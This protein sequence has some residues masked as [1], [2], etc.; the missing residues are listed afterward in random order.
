MAGACQIILII[1]ANTPGLLHEITSIIAKSWLGRCVFYQP[2][3]F[4]WI[5]SSVADMEED[6]VQRI[7]ANMEE[8]WAA[9]VAQYR[10]FGLNLPPFDPEGRFFSFHNDGILDVQRSVGSV[11]DGWDRIVEIHREAFNVVAQSQ[12]RPGSRLCDV[13]ETIEKIENTR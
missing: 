13:I 4:Y 7:L 12:S 6:F 8:S 3:V 10:A 2:P 9:V 11:A 5:P 1:P